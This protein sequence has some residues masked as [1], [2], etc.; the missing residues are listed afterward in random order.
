[1]QHR[2]TDVSSRLSWCQC[3]RID[4]GLSRMS[5][6]VRKLVHGLNRATLGGLV[7]DED[8]CPRVELLLHLEDFRGER[9]FLCTIVGP[10]AGHEGFDDAAQGV[11]TE[12]L[13]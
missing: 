13:M 10:L 8:R 7:V 12:N 11:R 4:R 9:D 5:G 6:M 3:R 2:L 1:M